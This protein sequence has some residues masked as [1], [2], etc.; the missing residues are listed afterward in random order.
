[1]NW[2]CRTSLV[3]VIAGVCLPAGAAL[4]STKVPRFD[5]SVAKSIGFLEK[6]AAKISERDHSL[7]AYALFKAG[8][9]ADNPIVSE[10][11]A[12]AKERAASK[13]YSGYDHIYLSGVD[14]ML[15]SD[16]DPDGYFQEL[17]NIAD[18]VVS[19]QR[20]NGSWSDTS[21]APGDVSMSQYGILALWA[22]QRAGCK[23]APNAFDNAAS[24]FL[25]G[26]NGDGGW[27]Y[28]P[29]TTSGPGAGASTHNMTLAGAGSL[30]VSRT[31]LHGPKKLAA[32]VAA[33]PEAKFGVLE[34]ASDAA[35]EN[36]KGLA[37]PNYKPTNSVSALD[38]TVSRAIG[39]N[40]T[41]FS[42]VSKSEHKIYFYYCLERAAALE[43]LTDGWYEAYGDGLLS[44]QSADG[45]FPTHP[46]PGPMAATSF[47][48]L[49]F[50][51]ST[52]QILDKQFGKG[53]LSGNRGLDNL[54]GGKEKEKKELGPLDE[55]LGAMEKADLS[56]LDEIST[57]DI[58]EKVTFSSRDEL[59]GQID[60]L[61]NLLKSKDAANRQ[62]AYWA[63]GRTGDF[64]LVP[65]M[66]QGLRDPNVDCNVEALNSLRYIS[67]KPNGFGLTLTPLAGKN[68]SSEDEKLK[69]VNAWRT[70]VWKTW[71]DWYRR[72]RP[73][74][75]GGG[76][77]E[78]E[79]Q[80]R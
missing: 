62:V 16:V 8:I 13:H 31:M 72:V 73:Y 55:L 39:W 20:S 37:F 49:Y 79:L 45:S 2:I 65:M 11:I 29:G 5:A 7:V 75:E 10:G 15:L 57:E 40:Q 78:L 63:L 54:F 41:R 35:T 50:M 4:K 21:T 25:K 9:P 17:Q 22:A 47:A 51:R 42:P 12:M 76:L 30:A 48:I 26:R 3:V 34:K 68:T 32:E 33:K 14:A 38:D 18:Y 60:M 19:A 36:P 43:D 24:F 44:L 70:T 71:G 56:Q 64:S 67:R 23:V 52:Q 66:L 59:V 53:I 74:D 46:V 6:N 61:K 77:D 80:A 28:R 27:G 1:M 58:V 69:I